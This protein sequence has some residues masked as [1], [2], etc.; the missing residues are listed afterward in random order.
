MPNQMSWR[1]DYKFTLIDT[2][3]AFVS[4]HKVCMYE[5]EMF[6]LYLNTDE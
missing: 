6:I 3:V 1:L 5:S 2:Y 4:V